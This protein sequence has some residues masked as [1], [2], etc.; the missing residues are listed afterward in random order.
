MQQK[1]LL[2]CCIHIKTPYNPRLLLGSCGF[3]PQI[4]REV[5]QVNPNPTLPPQR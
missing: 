4:K 2:I 1:E 3:R 5:G